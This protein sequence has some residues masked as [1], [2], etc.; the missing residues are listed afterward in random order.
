MENS[1]NSKLR[2]DEIREGDMVV[3]RLRLNGTSDRRRVQ[4]IFN[5]KI[6]VNLNGCEYEID[7]SKL[8]RFERRGA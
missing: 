1:K 7:R 6:F 2:F 5:G 3:F 8:I 4:K